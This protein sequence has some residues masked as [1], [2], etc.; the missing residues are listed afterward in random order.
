[1]IA[2]LSGAPMLPSYMIRQPDGRFMGICGDVIR[3]DATVPT[4]EA[5]ITRQMPYSAFLSPN[6]CAEVA[7]L[8]SFG[9]VPVRAA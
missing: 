7:M 2:Y 6:V 9:D 5:V 1:M 8:F 3:V 4:E